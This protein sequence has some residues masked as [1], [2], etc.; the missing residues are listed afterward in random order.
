MYIAQLSDLHVTTGELGA[1][2][3]ARARDALLRVQALRPRPDFVVITGDLVDTGADAEYELTRTLLDAVDIAVHVLPGNHDNATRVLRHLGDYARP[4]AGEPNRCYY[5]VDDADVTLICCDTSVPG[6][7]HGRLGP[8]QLQWLDEQL[9]DTENRTV[10]LAM[11]HHPVPTGIAGMD[12]IM[13]TDADA[14]GDVLRRHP[15]VSRVLCGHLHRAITATLAGAVV[16]SAPSTYR[17]V[18]LDLDGEPTVAFVDEPPAL[19]LHRISGDRVVTHH[20]PIGESG[21]PLGRVEIAPRG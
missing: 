20:V 15:P 5:R 2:P 3:A 10:I 16:M 7:P 6:H 9:A 8:E 12:A 17:Q 11:H 19:L 4:G 1:E 14:L 13:L 18:H 21:P